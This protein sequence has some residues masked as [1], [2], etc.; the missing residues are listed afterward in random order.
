MSFKSD[1]C[2]IALQKKD[3]LRIVGTDFVSPNMMAINTCSPTN[4]STDPKRESL[5]GIAGQ[6]P[7]DYLDRLDNLFT[8]RM[9]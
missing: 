6:G 9:V 8:V 5:A 2:K 1:S 4:P 3:K 7:P